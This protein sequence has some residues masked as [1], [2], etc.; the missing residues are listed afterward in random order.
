MRKSLLLAT[1]VA[2][3]LTLGWTASQAPA[4]GTAPAAGAS[5]AGTTV[6]VIDVA[7]VLKSHQRFQ[8][9]LGDIKKEMS[10]FDAYLRDQQKLM[11]QEGERLKTFNPGSAEYQQLEESLVDKRSDLSLQ[12]QRKR[13][14]ILDKEAQAYFHA[15]NEVYDYIANF[16]SRYNIQ[17]VLD[18]DSEQIDVKDYRAVAQGINRTVVYQRELNIT[19]AIIDGLNRGTLP[20]NARPAGPQIPRQR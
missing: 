10:D 1:L 9:T 8:A 15:Y 12:V 16:A 17:L 3:V 11:T 20:P 18:F 6:A 5:P 7:Y 2:F 13:K 4:Q 14:E 19:N